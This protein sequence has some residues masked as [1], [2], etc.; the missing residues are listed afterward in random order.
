MNEQLYHTENHGHNYVSMSQSKLKP[1]GERGP[2]G[3]MLTNIHHAESL[4][5]EKSN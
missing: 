5:T 3:T 2:R 4:T 1:V